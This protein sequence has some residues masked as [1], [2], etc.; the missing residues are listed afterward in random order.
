METELLSE[1]TGKLYIKYLIPS[2]GGALATSVYSFVDTIAVGQSC[3]PVGAAAIA[4]INPLFALACFVGLLVGIGSSVLMSKAKGAGEMEK[5]SRIFTASLM[6]LAVLGIISWAFTCI[7]LRPILAFCGADDEIMPYAVSYMIPIAIGLPLFIINTF[8]APVIRYDEHPGLVLK[9][10]LTG[11]CL[12]IFGDWFFVFP[13]GMDMFGAGLATALGSLTQTL[14]LL[15][16]FFGGKSSLKIKMPKSMAKDFRQ[17]AVS[18]FGASILDVAIGALTIMINRQT[19]KYGGKDELAVLGVIMTISFLLQHLY[20][21]IG[22]AVQ[23]IASTAFGAGRKDRVW[24]SF[25][26][27]LSSSLIAGLLSAAIC[28]FFPIPI[29]RLFI[30]ATENVLAI[31]P[32]I[33][34]IYSLSFLPMAVNINLVF[35]LQSILAP[36]AALAFSLSR[37]VVISLILLYILP[38]F[39]GM[40]GILW[41]MV[42]AEIITIIGA[43]PYT[44]SLKRKHRSESD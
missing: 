23:P 18:G 35:F 14:I 36:G 27:L 8:L 1:S 41:A 28:I 6:L 39:M 17:I 13:L 10:V 37:G 34:I 3:G 7:F 15:S 43:L 12:N 5:S 22:Q 25:S 19:M 20:A 33:V 26:Y 24:Q 16:N 9:A 29:L 2:L 30:D 42:L 44:L 21:G 31:G 4:V 40:D 38:L 11:G 32:H